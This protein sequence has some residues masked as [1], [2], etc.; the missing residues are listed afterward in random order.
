MNVMK[1]RKKRRITD[2]EHENRRSLSVDST[3]SAQ[4]KAERVNMTTKIKLK[5]GNRCRD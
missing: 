3:K 5:A 1:L 4:H 2:E